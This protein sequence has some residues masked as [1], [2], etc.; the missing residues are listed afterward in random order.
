MMPAS[1][2][3]TVRLSQVLQGIYPLHENDDRE[4]TG[5]ALDSRRVGKGSLFMACKGI[6]VDGRHYVDQAIAAGAAAVLVEADEVNWC[7]ESERK[8][9]PILPILNLQEQM[10]EVASRFHGEP[11]RQMRLIGVTGTNGK[12]TITQLLAAA[13]A[14]IGHRCGVI[15]TLGHGI[16]GAELADNGAGPGTTPDAVALQYILADL[17]EQSA[18][19]VVME[20]SSHA[21]DQR[22]VLVDDYA[23]AVFTNLSRDHLDYHGTME[24]YG[25]AKRKLFRGSRLQLAILNAD[26]DFVRETERLL[27]GEVRRFTWSLHNAKADVHAQKLRFTPKGMELEVKTPWGEFAFTSLLLGSFNASNLLGVLTTVLA[28]SSLTPGFDPQQLVN[29]V[30]SLR[31]V[32]GRMQVIAGFALDVVVDYAHSPDGLANALKAVREHCA[33]K[34][35]CVVGCGGNRDRGKRPQMASLAEQLADVVVLTDDNPREES[36]AAI[37]ADMQSGLANASAAHVIP[38]RAKAIEFAISKAGVGDAV[39]IAGKGHEQYQEVAGSRIVFSD[40]VV[41]R[42]VLQQR[43]GRA[44][45][46]ARA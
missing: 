22:R 36:S 1:T 26:D 32:P 4:L 41:A 9:A 2:T 40:E 25:A 14:A 42:S 44:A 13:F 5:V 27:D 29:A 43:F 37:I 24:N 11:G 23:I 17:R 34:V 30:A 46:E 39:L 33:G 31:P 28:A 10:A 35:F 38:D 3:Q 15:G 7:C 21:L 19:T 45:W 18:K 16:S 8:G 20:V 12:T 6:H